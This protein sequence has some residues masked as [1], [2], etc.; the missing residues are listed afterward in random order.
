MV[1]DP[2]ARRIEVIVPDHMQHIAIGRRG[3][4][5]RLASQLTGWD[6]DIMSEGEDSE[7]RNREFTEATELF[8][9]ALNV[10]EVIA[11]LL[12]TE[13]FSTVEDVAYSEVD[14]LATIEGFDEEIA[15]ALKER[16]Y[17]YLEEQEQLLAQE[18]E[19]LGVA[20][21][22]REFPSIDLKS[23][24]AL[25]KKGVKTLEDVA[26][27]AADELVELLAREAPIDEATA[28]NLILEARLVLGWI[29]PEPEDAADGSETAADA[30][31]KRPETTP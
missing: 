28:G 16:G 29:E 2:E 25:A 19:T 3:Q 17:A 22:L 15:E 10:E 1:L 7:R 11:Q 23:K 9:D 27:L 14:E 31:E 12:A 6:I 13:G 26:D 30:T 5:V 8:I 4:N 20:E 21:D 18:A 24:V